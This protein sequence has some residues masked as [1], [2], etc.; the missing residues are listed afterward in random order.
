MNMGSE[1]VK[2]PVDSLGEFLRANKNKVTSAL[3]D[4]IDFER[5]A[6]VA[7]NTLRRTPGLAKCSPASVLDAVNRCAELG[8]EPGGPLGHAYLI[9]FGSECVLV[10]GFKGYLHLM[11][12]S[13]GLRDAQAH[14]VY[15]NDKFIGNFGTEPR[16]EHTIGFGKRG[17]PIGAYC[18]LRYVNGG[19]HIEA[20]NM[21]E[22]KAVQNASRAGTA[23][24][25]VDW[26][27][28]MA[29][30]TVLKRAA[31]WGPTGSNL[32]LMAKAA[33]Y[34]GDTVDGSV[35]ANPKP[36]PPSQST[37]ALVSENGVS[38]TLDNTDKV[39]NS[40]PAES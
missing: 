17:K 8:L 23:G 15:E 14:V 7:M 19:S 12:R 24:P 11:F 40:V 5:F 3:N 26:W 27:A 37:H 22:L 33:E 10:V 30:K 39:K 6:A 31:K 2:S 36:T 35:I 34:D 29:K 21:D 16:I 1:I 13:G 18:V 20:M 4:A 32:E 38:A 25:W 28:E 9:P